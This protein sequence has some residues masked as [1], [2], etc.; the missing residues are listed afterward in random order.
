MKDSNKREVHLTNQ[1][2]RHTNKHFEI[3]KEEIKTA[4]DEPNTFDKTTE[5]EPNT[6]D[7]TTG[8]EPN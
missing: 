3:T 4:G 2:N 6:F 1:D 8:A 5:D 7:K